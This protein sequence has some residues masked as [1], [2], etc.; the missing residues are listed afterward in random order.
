MKFPQLIIETNEN[1]KE[2]TLFPWL[3]KS[4]NNVI[5]KYD[6]IPIKENNK[7][8]IVSLNFPYNY[9]FINIESNGN[10]FKVN[11]IH[12]SNELN[13]AIY[14]CEGYNDISYNLSN[15]KYKIPK[16]VFSDY[17]LS[18][19]DT[20]NKIKHIDY[21]F[22]NFLSP[23]LPPQ[24]YLLVQSESTYI[25]SILY[26]NSSNNIYGILFDTKDNHI[27]IPSIAIKRLFDCLETGFKYSNF[28]ADY[29]LINN[30][31]TSGIKIIKS[32]YKNILTDDVIV[33]IN[34]LMI[35][36]GKINYLKIN[37]WVPIEVY[38]WY[39][40]LPSMKIDVKCYK[41][42]IYYHKYIPFI[43]FNNMLKIPF[44]NNKK[45][46]KV[47]RLTFDLLEYLYEKNIILKNDLVDKYLS[48]PYEE[49]NLII[50]FDEELIGRKYLEPTEITNINIV[51]N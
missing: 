45:E 43:D 14:S 21:H 28:F 25:G 10:I 4:S 3:L 37:E 18:N 50:D 12:S 16:S 47:M 30:P 13:L 40:W 2:T 23:Y 24:A 46:S 33:D 44:T 5:I 26:N 51:E 35:L 38:L 49:N 42:S 29:K 20:P 7:Q 36:N 17:Y 19:H 9:N 27:V 8:Y 11:L 41:N 22:Y 6:A 31:I 1:F 15:L 39:E 32:Y 48:E 34:N